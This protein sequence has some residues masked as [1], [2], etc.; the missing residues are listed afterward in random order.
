MTYHQKEK[1]LLLCL[2]V[3]CDILIVNIKFD[4]DVSVVVEFTTV[5]EGSVALVSEMNLTARDKC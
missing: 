4:T 1:I 3:F 5:M 2:W